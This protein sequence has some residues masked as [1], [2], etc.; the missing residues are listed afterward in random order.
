[1]DGLT[2]L[3]TTFNRGALLRRSLERLC[4]L[5][6]PDEL[7]VVD[8]GG[9]DE[10]EAVCRE[11][12]GRLPIRYVYN[13]NPGS[14]I[15]SLA[16]NIGVKHA[17]HERIVTC[18]PELI[19]RTDVISQFQVLAE[20]DPDRVISAGNVVFLPAEWQG[21]DPP[22]GCQVAIGWVAP[23]AALYRKSWLEEVGG[24]DEGFPGSWGWDDTDLLTRLRLAG[25]GQNRALEIEALHQ[26]HGTGADP[27]SVNETYWL[28]K[29]FHADWTDLT[30]MVANQGCDWG[31][32]R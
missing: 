16:R 11:F 28:S 24:W 25:H 2:L 27:G 22:P 21:G 9:Q 1:M 26:F 3:I 17:S 13:N 10:T 23:Y 6:R 18:E 29:G 15:C 19:F 31:R 14:T 4:E 12:D 20:E 5:T 32:L 30:D 7:I 8:D